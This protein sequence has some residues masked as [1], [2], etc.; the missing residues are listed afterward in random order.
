M[1]KSGV[2]PVETAVFFK[3][4]FHVEHGEIGSRIQEVGTPC[5]GAGSEVSADR[6]WECV[7]SGWSHRNK[8][9]AEATHPVLARVF[10]QGWVA[11]CV[12]GE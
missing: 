2:L 8:M 9:L 3:K 10:G 7:V 5:P 4:M 12:C 11:Q 1:K 6:R